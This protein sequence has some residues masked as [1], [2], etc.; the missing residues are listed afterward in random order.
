[1]TAP[2][3]CNIGE[4][5]GDLSAEPVS[6]SS[7]SGSTLRGWFI[8]GQ[9]RRGIVILAHGVRSNR[10]AMLGRARFLSRSGHSV[11]LFD[12]QAHGE[13]PG[14]R[15]T[16]GH[17][18]SRDAQAAVQF[19]HSRLPQERTAAIGCSLGGAACLLGESPLKVDALVLEAVY[20][21]VSTAIS[22]RLSLRFGS[23]GKLLSPLL[24]CQLKPRLGVGPEALCPMNGIRKV[25]CPVLMIA[26]TQDLRTT[27]EESRAIFA[28]A[29]EP[30]TLWEVQGAAHEDFH[31]Y[32]RQ[33][34]E[35]IVG[36]FLALHLSR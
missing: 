23:F 6:F 28:A 7:E 29:P 2:A 30:K 22:N 1:M 25:E 12:F 36:E 33:G 11:L 16:L 3:N 18:E 17:L 31:R 34:Y 13:S 35:K 15:I 10:S 21:D 8:T 9:P 27:I 19:A 24:L 20:S 4:P 5:P 32:A 26:G 14:T